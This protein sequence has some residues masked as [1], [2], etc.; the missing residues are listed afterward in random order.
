[1]ITKV[2][3]YNFQSHKKSIMEFVPGTNVIIG[4]SDTGK[5]AVFRAI[6]WVCSNR[7]LGDSFRSE[8]GGDTHVILH[9]S[10]GNT[11]ERIRTATK[12]AYIINGQVLE[13]FGHS[14]PEDVLNI[15]QIDSANIHAQMDPPFLLSSTPGEAAQMLNTAA[16]I[17]DIDHTIA[18]LKR[19]YNQIDIDIKHAKKQHSEVS[20]QLKKYENLPIIEKKLREVEQQEVYR[21]EMEES[22]E[23]LRRFTQKGN[24]INS[25]LRDTE[26][27]PILLEKCG[28]V[29]KRNTRYQNTLEQVEKLEKTINKA[30]K[31]QEELKET[32]HIDNGFVILKNT[33]ETFSKWKS[34]TEQMAQV[35]RALNR[36]REVKTVLS[37]TRYFKKG[38][39]LLEEAE[40]VFSNWKEKN[41]QQEQL[42]QVM[43][44]AVR[45]KRELDRLKR[46]VEKLEEEFHELAPEQCP[47]CG[48]RLEQGCFIAM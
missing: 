31:I 10:E 23:D 41:Y 29:E 35:R 26:Y 27:I 30:R 47:L 32:I 8:W 11:I 37:S 24:H 14:V 42:K 22:L 46:K 16:S 48:N 21:G 6:N 4:A 45:N 25:Q 33:E 43:N 36:A 20:E 15:L 13:A 7:P 28:E 12:N 1:M 18:G 3:I 39:R 5:S 17:D 19:S 34:K 9:T 44:Q 38:S 2:E 40:E